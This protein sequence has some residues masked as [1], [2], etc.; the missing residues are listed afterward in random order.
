[1]NGHVWLKTCTHILKLFLVS[2][3]VPECVCT[4]ENGNVGAHL[5]VRDK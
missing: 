3:M 2:F 5:L 1:M 4:P